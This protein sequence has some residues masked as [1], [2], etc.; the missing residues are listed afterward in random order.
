MPEWLSLYLVLCWLRFIEYVTWRPAGAV[1][2]RGG[3]HRKCAAV[4]RGGDTARAGF[5]LGNPLLPLDGVYVSGSGS[6]GGFDVAA[7]EHSLDAYRDSA[8]PLL[9][10]EIALSIHLFVVLPVVWSL[11]GIALSWPYLLGSLLVL[12]LVVL[13]TF[14]RAHRLVFG[15]SR[16]ERWS[17]AVPFLLAPPM[18]TAAHLAI[19]K[20]MAR[21]AHPMAAGSLLCT[22]EAFRDLALPYVRRSEYPVS[23][24]DPGD[25]SE[26]PPAH[27]A[28]LRAL[29]EG[30]LG[31]IDEALEAPVRQS[32]NA[33]AYCPRC[34]A[35][36]SEGEGTCV[37]CGGVALRSFP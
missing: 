6:E 11:I 27:R 5:A 32:D 34:L 35:E 23:D 30:R 9:R 19:T 18:A 20:G 1:V 28:D 22:D 25:R 4:P 24:V 13:V 31:R 16:A 26:T 14:F 3:S 7:L 15:S 33:Q 2:F 8:R 10:A 37:D 36:Y 12:H 29:A 17:A 21:D